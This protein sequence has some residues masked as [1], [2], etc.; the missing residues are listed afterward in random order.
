MSSTSSDPRPGVSIGLPVYNGEDYLAAALDSI[1][2]QTYEDFELIICDNDSTDNTE[3]I[4]Q[5]YAEQDE[6]IRYHRNKKNLGAARNYNR[7]LEMARAPYFRWA[8]HDDK[9]HPRCIEACIDVLNRH[10]EVVLAYPQTQMIDASGTPIEDPD[11]V[12]NLDLRQRR[13]SQRF[14]EYLRRYLWGGGGGQLF[15]LMRTEVLRSTMRH[16]DFP[17]ADLVLIGEMTLRGQIYE[18]PERLFLRRLHEENSIL[19][20]DYKIEKIWEWFD[21]EQAERAQWLEWRWLKEYVSAINRAPLRPMETLRCYQALTSIYV[22][23]HGR[24]LLKEILYMAGRRM[25]VAR[26]MHSQEVVGLRT[27]YKIF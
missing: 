13:P 7:T 15:G 10:P 14:A 16:G 9:L 27:R 22:A 20:N 8:C 6:R 11:F 3:A 5:G 4:C 26:S 18:I 21:P 12:V 24:K 2:S 23:N 25:G 17:S 1:L 19:S